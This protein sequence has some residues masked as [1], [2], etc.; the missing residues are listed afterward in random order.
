M[1]LHDS[2]R[3][4]PERNGG[5]DSRGLAGT[6]RH[7]FPIHLPCVETL[8]RTTSIK[9]RTAKIRTPEY[10]HTR[11]GCPRFE[12]MRNHKGFVR[13]ARLRNIYHGLGLSTGTLPLYHGCY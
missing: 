8:Q 10:F 9:N 3:P 11:K 5:R 2:T 13:R 1:G 6:V 12:H 4:P 7:K